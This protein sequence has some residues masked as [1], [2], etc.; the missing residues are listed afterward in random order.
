MKETHEIVKLAKY[1]RVH[2]HE[3]KHGRE[4]MGLLEG[5]ERWVAQE[6]KECVGGGG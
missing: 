5:K 3:S 4:K 6:K 1:V 2:S